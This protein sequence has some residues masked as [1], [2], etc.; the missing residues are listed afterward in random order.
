MN[1]PQ[2]IPTHLV[3]FAAVKWD[4]PLIGRTRMLTESWNRSGQPTTFVEPPHSYRSCLARLLRLPG[5]RTPPFVIRPGP[6]K[7][8]VRWW[9]RM[10]PTRLRKM[11]RDC[12][13]SLRRQLDRRLKVADAAAILISPVWTPMIEAVGFGKV[14]YDCI[15][16]LS[17]HAPDPAMRRILVDW[18]RDLVRMCDAAVVTAEVL[19]DGL[20]AI[21]PDLPIEL[22]RNG[23]EAQAFIERAAK[24]PRPQD[25]PQAQ[26]P[27]VGF[28]GAL[29][30]WID[31]ELIGRAA[32]ALPELQFVFVGPHNN[33]S[34][35]SD[36]SKRP[37]VRVLGPRPYDIIPAYVAAFDV[38][39]VPFKVGEITAAANPVKIY[40]YLALARPVVTTTVADHDSFAGL[41]RVGRDHDQVIQQLRDA[42]ASGQPDSDACEEFVRQNSWDVRATQFQQIVKKLRHAR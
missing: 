14:I 24:L 39:W 27:T 29:Y 28:V 19:G 35:V 22:I 41:V 8:P 23:V 31:W 11:M 30:E 7:Y 6:T 4:F 26:S 32:D 10:S 5:T 16:S 36:L 25:I 21:R 2:P 34:A 18:E 12:G 9:T 42:I 20:R 15:D 40:E 3:S 17:V 37:N 13:A 33:A 1:P 38:C